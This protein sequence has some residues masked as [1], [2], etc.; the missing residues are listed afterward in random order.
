M[1]Q[2]SYM[3]FIPFTLTVTLKQDDYEHFIREIW[4]IWE[5]LQ[6]L[7]SSTP[8]Q[9]VIDFCFSKLHQPY[10]KKKKIVVTPG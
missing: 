7:K 6:F 2:L 10:D 3:F 9:G 8:P 4:L 1:Y 5:L